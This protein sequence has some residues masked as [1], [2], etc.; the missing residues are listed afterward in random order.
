MN[1]YSISDLFHTTKMFIKC[2]HVWFRY[3]LCYDGL[4]SMK[5]GNPATCVC[6]CVC[7]REREKFV[8]TE[9]YRDETMTM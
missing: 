6:V 9:Q 5:H 2:V 4:Y 8:N 7:E 1:N 3:N